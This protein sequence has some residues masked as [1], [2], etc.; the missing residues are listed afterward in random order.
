MATMYEKS[1]SCYEKINLIMRLQK[2]SFCDDILK[3][4]LHL[5]RKEEIV[6]IPRGTHQMYFF[7]TDRPLVKISL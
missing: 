4:L 1:K 2:Y 6:P 7:F 3:I 5:T